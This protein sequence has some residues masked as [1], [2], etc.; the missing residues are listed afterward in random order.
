MVRR[1]GLHG[2]PEPGSDFRRS[3][4]VPFVGADAHIGPPAAGC[5]A[6]CRPHCPP[7]LPHARFAAGLWETAP[8][9]GRICNPPLQTRFRFPRRGGLHGRP[10]QLPISA[11]VRWFP[12]GVCV[13]R[14]YN[15]RGG[16]G[17]SS[18]FTVPS[19]S[20]ASLPAGRRG[21]CLLWRRIGCRGEGC[22]WEPS[23][24]LRRMWGC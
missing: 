12:Y 9:P 13:L 5:K 14:W 11:G 4:L 15:R 19:P 3:P 8:A 2:R 1:G 17:H 7:S 10:D 22:P 6:V 18:Y 20:T 21:E 24:P 23:R 16:W